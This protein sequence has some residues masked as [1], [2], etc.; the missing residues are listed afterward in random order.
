LSFSILLGFKNFQYAIFSNAFPSASRIPA[1]N[2]VL[3]LQARGVS[4]HFL[5][6]KRSVLQPASG[7][8]ISRFRAALDT[9]DTLH[10]KYNTC[11]SRHLWHFASKV[12][13]V[14]IQTNT[15]QGSF[16]TANHHTIFFWSLQCPT[17]GFTNLLRSQCAIPA[18]VGMDRQTA[19]LT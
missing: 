13:H 16:K 10:Q 8:V 19:K 5:S 15:K 9:Y 14:Y 18:A 4:N 1:L 17:Q 12:Q 11:C 6:T 2:F 3:S 7:Q